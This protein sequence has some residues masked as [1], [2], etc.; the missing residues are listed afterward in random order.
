MKAMLRK[1]PACRISQPIPPFYE[2][3]LQASSLVPSIVAGGTRGNYNYGWFWRG[4]GQYSGDEL[5]RAM[6][7]PSKSN[8]G[9]EVA[10]HLLDSA[11]GH[12]IQSWRFSDQDSITIG[13][14]DDNDVVI[15]DRHVSRSHVRLTRDGGGWT[16]ISV[17]R[18]G[19]L[20]S[21][22]LISEF[23]VKDRVTFR[24]G[25]LGPMMRFEVGRE[26][27][28]AMTMDTIDPDMFKMLE[29]DEQRKQAEVD[30]I[31]KGALFEDLL[32]QSQRFKAMRQ[33]DDQK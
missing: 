1:G 24:L 18:H 11:Q 16:L 32:Q 30:A 14:E 9:S 21:E 2:R 13:R 15:S 23:A 3:R 5:E 12:P 22:E 27:T 25:P 7:A 8:G 28:S 4:G 33:S 26:E 19:T 10:L 17:G 31:A 29:V 6:P 20:V